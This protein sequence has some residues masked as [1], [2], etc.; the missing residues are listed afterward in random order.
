MSLLSLDA[1]AEEGASGLSAIA[2]EG[3]K[4]SEWNGFARADFQIDGRG[5]IVVAPKEVATGKPWIWR[6]RFF[7][8]E[9]QTDIALLGKGYHLVYMDVVNMYGAPVAVAHWNEFY[10]HLVGKHGFAKKAVLEGMSRGG[11]IIFNWAKVNPEKVAC[12]YGDAPVCDIRSWPGGKGTSKGSK[13][14]WERCK[15][16]YGITEVDVGGFKG[17]PIDGLEPLAKA[18]VPILIVC[19]AADDVVPMVENTN[20]LK[21]RYEALGGSIRV[22]AKEGVGHHPHSLKDPTEIVDFIRKHAGG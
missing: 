10:A 16:A 3:A 19:G 4:M 8:H 18:G 2:G 5:C 14:D 17:N 6:A 11:L 15:Q 7:G 21:E 22:I 9:P 20:V 13:G 1:V 12:I